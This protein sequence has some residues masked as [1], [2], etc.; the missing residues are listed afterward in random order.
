[1]PAATMVGRANHPGPPLAV[2]E[3]EGEAVRAMTQAG[4]DRAA[5]RAA[6]ED[7]PGPMSGNAYKLELVEYLLERIVIAALDRDP[8]PGPTAVA[9]ADR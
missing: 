2:S 4:H 5:P 9:A 1:M 3:S 7:H 8:V 6:G